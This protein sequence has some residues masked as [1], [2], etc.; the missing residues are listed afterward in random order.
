VAE[1]LTE[2]GIVIAVYD[3]MAKV[4]AIRSSSCD[5]CAAREICKPTGGTEV[6]IEAINE[7][8]ASV[9]ERVKISMQ[10]GT[11]LKA[12]FIAYILPLIGF[13]AGGIVGKW[14]GGTDTSAAILGIVFLVLTY[15]G[16]WLYNKKG[17]REK[18]KPVIVAILTP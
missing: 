3:H 10:P 18:Y 5:G 17:R 4:R 7:I 11:L 14:I 12:S 9:G 13:L 15:G 2:E 6:I 16:I 8:G 1:E